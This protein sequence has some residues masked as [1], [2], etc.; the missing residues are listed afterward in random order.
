VKVT[1]RLTGIDGK[2]VSALRLSGPSL[3][4]PVSAALKSDG[5]FEFPQLLPGAYEMQVLPSVVPFL[6]TLTVPSNDVNNVVIAFPDLRNVAGEFI[7]IEAGEFVMGCSLD[8]LQCD[9]N[10]KPQHRVGITRPFEIGKYEVTQAQWET[11][12][13]TNPSQFKGRDRP[14]ENVNEWQTAQEYIQKL[15]ALNDGYRYRLPTEAEWEYAARAGSTAWSASDLEAMA[16]HGGN[17][18]GSTRPVGEKQPNAWG[19]YDTQGNVWEWVQDWYGPA[20]YSESPALDPQGPSTGPL[21]VLRGGSWAVPPSN[22]RVSYRGN[23]RFGGPSYS[24]GLRLV[25]ERAR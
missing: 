4:E 8:D 12:M 1:G 2:P 24:Y 19:L 7:R 17:S 16:W 23:L 21:H 25:R 3:G 10:E 6:T 20:Y 9:G 18:G 22:A 15:N 13:G 14:V 5:S 11:I